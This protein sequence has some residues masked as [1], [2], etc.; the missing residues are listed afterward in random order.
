MSWS[1]L[2]YLIFIGVVLFFTFASVF[3]PNHTFHWTD[4]FVIAFMMFITIYP[5]VKFMILPDYKWKKFKS[6]GGSSVATVIDVKVIAGADPG[7]PDS[8]VPNN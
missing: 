1:K 3:S 7:D 5:F 6:S 2:L 8:Y 4:L